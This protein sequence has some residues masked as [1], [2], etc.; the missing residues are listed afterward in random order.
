[1]PQKGECPALEDENLEVSVM[2]Q[3]LDVQMYNN[4]I[5]DALAEDGGEEEGEEEAV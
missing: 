4:E 1:M 2:S 3:W 5:V